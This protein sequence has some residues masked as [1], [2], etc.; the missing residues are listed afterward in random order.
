M[1]GREIQAAG[2][3]AST[4][5]MVAV[6]LLSY[7][8]TFLIL[9]RRLPQRG[10]EGAKGKPS[11][12]RPAAHESCSSGC[13]S[14]PSDSE[15]ELEP[16]HVGCSSPGV[17][18]AGAERQKP[19]ALSV[20]FRGRVT[21]PDF[22]L[23]GLVALVLLRYAVDY[24]NAAKSLQVVVLLTGIVV[25]KGAALWTAWPKRP[26]TLSLSPSEGERVSA[27]RVR[28]TL[29]I[30]AFL[31][32]ATAL[33][34]PALGM[35]FHY[36]GVRRWEGAW[37]NPNTYGL[38]MGVGLVLAL[39][40]LVQNLASKVQSRV[41]AE[42]PTSNIQHSTLN[43][44]ISALLLV[45]AGLCSFGLIKSYSRGAWL[46]T[47]VGM[48]FLL[49]KWINREPRE[50]REKLA[51][52]KFS[53][54]NSQPST[55]PFWF[56]SSILLLAILVICF[57]QFRHTESPLLR[58]VF[59]V[60]NV[61]DFSWRNRVTAWLGAGR[62]MLDKPLAGF[63]W[64]KAE[65][66]YR[67]DYRAARLEE[68][69]AIQLN[70][71]LMLATSAGVPALLCL[72]IC[73]SLA[74]KAATREFRH[75]T[76]ALSMIPEN[77]QHPTPNI[78][79]PTAAAAGALVLLIGFWFDGGLFK[80]PTCVVFWVLLELARGGS[81]GNEAQCNWGKNE[82]PIVDEQ[83]G[84]TAKYPKHANR[85]KVL[86]WTA[87]VVAT[88]A[89]GQT[90]LHLG[91]PQLAV[92]QRTLALTRQW[93]VPTKEKLE[94]EFLAAK[95]VWSGR[96]LR[97]LLQHAHLANYNR[98][99]VNWKVDDSV[100]QSF[101]LSPEIDPAFDGEMNWR[102]RLWEFFY[103]RVRKETSLAAATE[104]VMRQVR[105]RVKLVA[106]EDAPKTIG[107]MW[108]Q[109]RADDRGL[110]ALGVAALRSVGIPARLSASGTAEFRDD[111]G[112]K[113]AN[114]KPSP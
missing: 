97:G 6:C 32:A 102:R 69:A 16:T 57:W 56:P 47:A 112:W 111:R 104:V 38:L 95:P 85:R 60:G 87:G 72:F 68:T 84:L 93:L 66:A 86:R 26:L 77:I 15:K 65:E 41:Q 80:L 70:D 113:T 24:A 42:H 108:R 52:Q 17:Q 43:Y 110:E 88:L 1:I 34:Q 62:M 101:V 30:L 96:P 48:G 31:L 20:L 49:W 74:M 94:F 36:R 51:G 92:S 91:L 11:T 12:L 18:S 28:G 2:R 45:T 75:L 55:S 33:W 71:Y 9:E 8:V 19:F 83:K 114:L 7:F 64:G 54:F 44:V 46:G 73:I 61:N 29:C 40:L 100:Y 59:S 23:V 90:V 58:R 25:G 63:G 27:G 81:R 14:A 13:E 22:W 105:E 79:G 89:I 107:E 3:D 109:E 50:I 53:T 78:Q 5:W 76:P 4:Q 21:N 82:E 37:E 99:L 106:A 67:Q 39:G 103:P 10:T 98:G 35:E